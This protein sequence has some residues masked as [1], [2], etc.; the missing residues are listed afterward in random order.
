MVSFTNSAKHNSKWK[1]LRV[2]NGVYLERWDRIDYKR[3][4]FLLADPRY[5]NLPSFT[6]CVPTFEQPSKW[7]D[8]FGSRLRT[9]FVPLETG[10]HYFV[11]SSNAGSEL[12]LSKNEK[13]ET[14]SMI[15]YIDGGFPALK[16]E[17]DRFTNQKSLPIYLMK[18]RYY[19]MEAIMKDDHQ[20]YDH[21]EAGLYTPDGQFYNVIPSKFLWT[22]L[23]T[24]PAQNATYQA[25]LLKVAARAGAEAGLSF[26][27]RWAMK[28][29]AK[30]GAK[31]GALAGMEAGASAG[32]KAGTKA[33][34]EMTTKTL[35]DAFNSFHGDSLH[36]FKITIKNGSVVDITGPGMKGPL[37]M[38]VVVVAVLEEEEVV[39]EVA[40]VVV[41]DQRGL[42]AQQELQ[43]LPGQ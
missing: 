14:K 34:M 5:P 25:I 6:E 32:A 8:F 37:L 20:D 38:E 30:S 7:G 42:L 27:G 23:R 16:Y 40:V 2:A 3:V 41:V 28:T 4:K 12:F 35:Q 31:T 1:D 19:Y 29:G 17:Y 24:P 43:E 9:Y 26:G 33:A 15:T 22:T 10:N 36:K 39:E 18:G 21:L 11:L 13:P